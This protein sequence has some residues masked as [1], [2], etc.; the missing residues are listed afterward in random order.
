MNISTLLDMAADA[1]GDRT[2]VVCAET[3]LDY[4]TLRDKAWRAARHFQAAD[5][6]YVALLDVTSPAAPVTLFGAAYAGIPFVPLNYR[7]TKAEI[8]ALLDRVS[9]VLVIAGPDQLGQIEAREGVTAMTRDAL[10]SLPDDGAEP[11]IAPEDPSAVAVQLFTSGTTGAPK[12]AILR[13]ENLTSYIIGTVEFAAAE[14]TDAIVVTVPPYHIA[15]I[16]AVLSSTYA[17]RRMVQLE[18]FEPAAW[19]AAVR[20]EKVSNAFLVPTMLQRVVEHLSDRGEAAQLPSL[21]AL[22]YGGGKMPLTVIAKAMAL[23]PSVDFTNAYG[24][25]ETSSTVAVLGPDDHRMAVASDDPLIRRRLGSVG[26]A[27]GAVEIQIRNEDG[28]VLAAEDAGLVFVRGPQVSGEYLSQGSQLDAEG[29]FPTK[30]RGYL[31]AD[32][33]LFL[34][35]RDD[36]VIV[37]GGE[38]ISPGEIEDVLMTHP[39]VADVAVVA[40]PDEQWGEAVAAAV[41]CKPGSIVSDADLKALVRDRLRSSRVPQR[42]VFKAALPYTETGKLLRRVI[43]AELLS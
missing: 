24:L 14:E 15:G 29:W 30:D 12:A 28:A 42:I 16:S 13:H 27:T 7:L 36:D 31:D 41:V 6:E 3:R 35:G 22:A 26:R 40:M 17:C 1:F 43:R 9:P 5:V 37:R 25:T 34:D 20:N 23:F 38:N 33:Y 21:R 2:G 19:L 32:G 39:A 11:P 18:A 4:A 10:L 8:N